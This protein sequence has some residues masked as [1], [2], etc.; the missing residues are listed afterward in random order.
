MYAGPETYYS[1]NRLLFPHTFAPIIH[2]TM[3]LAS[4]TH[5]IDVAKHDMVV[6]AYDVGAQTI[7]IRI[8]LFKNVNKHLLIS[9]V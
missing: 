7:K 6:D 8:T 4:H 3:L 9:R 5:Q 2:H 1:S